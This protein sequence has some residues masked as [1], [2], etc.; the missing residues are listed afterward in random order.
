MSDFGLDKLTEYIPRFSAG[1]SPIG[2]APHAPII[3]NA[4]RANKALANKYSGYMQQ[5][6]KDFDPVLVR[7]LLDMDAQRVANGQSPLSEQE[8]RNALQTAAAG[9][10]PATPA[11]ER[12]LW[13]VPG[14][15][16]SDIGDIVK[17]IPRLPLALIHEVQ[18]LPTAFKSMQDAPNPLAGLLQA[19]GVRMIP[20]AYVA[21]NIAAGTPEEIAAHPVLSLLDVLPLA[22]GAAK[23]TAVAK[24][25]AEGAEAARM[26]LSPELSLRAVKRLEKQAARPI[27]TRLL[28]RLDD[29]GN[30]VRNQAGT[31]LDLTMRKSKIGKFLNQ[32]FAQGQADAMFEVNAAAART[33]KRFLGE[34]KGGFAPRTEGMEAG[35]DFAAQRIARLHDDLV[36]LDPTLPDRLPDLYDA[37]TQPGV[38]DSLTPVDHTAIEMYRES[39]NDLSDWAVENGKLVRF[40]NEIYDIDTGAAL[41]QYEANLHGKQ[42]VGRMRD[43]IITADEAAIPTMFGELRKAMRAPRKGASI[44]GTATGTQRMERLARGEMSGPERAMTYQGTRQAMRNA[45][46]DTTALEAAYK[47][48][49]TALIKYMDDVEAGLIDVPREAVMTL[50]QI[51]EH[52]RANSSGNSP[53]SLMARSLLRG[54]QK[55][56]WKGVS[57]ALDSLRKRPEFAD[58]AFV[59]GVTNVKDTAKLLDKKPWKRGTAK[60]IAQTESSMGKFRAANP[61]ARFI[62]AL[63]S[64]FRTR[65]SREL[66]GAQGEIAAADRWA[67]ADIVAAVNRT[68]WSEV[69]GFT[70]E[71]YRA[72][73]KDVVRTWETLK[74]EGFNPTFVH[75]VPPNKLTTALRPLEGVV[76]RT[77]SS[78]KRRVFDMSP[79]T[80]NITAALSHQAMEFVHHGEIELAVKHIMD[81]QGE[82]LANLKKMYRPVA[83]ARMG[84][85]SAL[86]YEGHLED[87]IHSDWRKFNPVEEGYN[88]GSPYLDKLGADDMYLPMGTYKNLKALADPHSIAGGVFDPV[89]RAFRI[90]VTGLSVRTQLY[91]ILGGAVALELKS[92]GALIRNFSQVREW[93]RNP[94]AIP[95]ELKELVGGQKRTIMEL[96][97]ES[98][99]LGRVTEGV[100]SYLA[101]RKLG[102]AWDTV[103]SMKQPGKPLTKAGD[104]FNR[105]VEKMYDLNGMFD[106]MYRMTAYLD[107]YS[108]GIAKGHTHEAAARAGVGMARKVLQDWMGMTPFE[109]NVVKS[110]IPFYG[111]MGHAIRYVLRYPMDHPLRA[112]FMAKLAHAELEDHNDGLPSR[113]LGMLFMGGMDENGNKRA[114][115]LAPFNPFGD[116]ANSMTIA[117]MLGATNPLI[118]TMFKQVG[119]DRGQ[120]ELYPSLRYDPE[121]G[122]LAAARGNFFADLL[123]NTIPQTDLL[124]MMIGQ[125]R[126]YADIASR[127]PEAARRYLLSSLTV[128]LVERPFNIPQEQYKAELARMKSMEAVKNAAL[129]SGD[130]SEALRYPSLRDYFDALGKLPQ[131]TRD[132]FAKLTQDQARQMAEQAMRGNGPMMIPQVAPLDDMVTQLLAAPRPAPMPGQ[133]I[134]PTYQGGV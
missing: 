96:D 103:Q 99:R 60:S 29:E 47:D 7:A 117:G 8:T 102:Q 89:T 27:A 50:P 55:E 71:M 86:N 85:S 111:F 23:G 125:N 4:P 26:G 131:D 24:A 77:A 21:G 116:V 132:Q 63:N 92:P 35:L 87:A 22:Q 115:N 69:P 58:P 100:R 78:V 97:N 5:L 36:A 133:S 95:D 121:T 109:R 74:R 1:T 114:L 25:A 3:V 15:A 28:N 31:L 42:R 39:L 37:M 59:R 130:W 43:Q 14:N 70:N 105:G 2:P 113:F 44:P 119:L 124:M 68:E 41:H 91:N 66:A 53:T 30:I 101:G 20:G 16:I 62:P 33:Q 127:D 73:E 93:M 40:D 52:V 34:A 81:M 6:T 54:I 10:K 129:K 48:S 120:A 76:P 57:Y 51:I 104:L 123:G 106:D 19:P 75:T 18:A 56:E 118:N 98:V 38:W 82:S 90:A 9:G 80:K 46:Y 72:V 65:L 79:G 13:N 83:E 108:K 32:T 67:V 61:P 84:K 45:G 11:P 128:P 112:E 17:A 107:E 94:A 122:R 110:I 134:Q 88:W 12:D 126:E 64:E 49:P